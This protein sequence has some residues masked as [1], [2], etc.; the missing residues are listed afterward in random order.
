VHSHGVDSF[1][2]ILAAPVSRLDFAKALGGLAGAFGSDLLRVKGLVG[3]ADQPDRPA[4][5][6][7][8]QHTMFAPEWLAAWPDEDR[9]SRLVFIVHDIPRGE[10]LTRFAAALPILL[11]AGE[12]PALH[13]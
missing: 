1:T 3:F 4:L 8:A 6:Q 7:A 5:V 9:R 11:P 12:M 10:V 13:P 2:V